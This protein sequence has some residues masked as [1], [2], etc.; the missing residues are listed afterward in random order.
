MKKESNSKELERAFDRLEGCI[1]FEGNGADLVRK[2]R[3]NGL[4]KLK[5]A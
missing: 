1:L 3:K 2:I 4:I 5:G